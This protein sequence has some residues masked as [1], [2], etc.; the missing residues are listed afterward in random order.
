MGKYMGGTIGCPGACARGVHD[1]MRNMIYW[2]GRVGRNGQIGAT[3]GES[4]RDKALLSPN[5]VRR[6]Q[7]MLHTLGVVVDR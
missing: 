6:G 7:Q 4:K 1:P 2:K 5:I 3:E